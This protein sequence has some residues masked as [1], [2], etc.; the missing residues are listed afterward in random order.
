MKATFVSV[1]NGDTRICTACE[2]NPETG[3]VTNVET[4]DTEI[5]GEL[6][7]QVIELNDDTVIRNFHT[8]DGMVVEDGQVVDDGIEYLD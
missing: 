7:E 4:S 5:D 8:E 1:W 3:L 2:Y 6:D